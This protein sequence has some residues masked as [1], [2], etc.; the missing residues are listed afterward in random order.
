MNADEAQMAADKTVRLLDLA[1]IGTKHLEPLSAFICA[2]SAFI[3]V[4]KALVV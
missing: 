1:S 4:F 3:C 2:S